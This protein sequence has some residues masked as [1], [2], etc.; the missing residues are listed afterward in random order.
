M[1]GLGDLLLL[2]AIVALV[3]DGILFIWDNSWD[4]ANGLGLLCFA[5]R[6][7]RSGERQGARQTLAT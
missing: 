2:A 7:R 6:H 1:N 3:I 4:I 5:S